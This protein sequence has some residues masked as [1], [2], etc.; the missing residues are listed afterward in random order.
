M[1][2]GWAFN[3]FQSLTELEEEQDR[4]KCNRQHIRDGLGQIYAEGGILYEAG[5]D[6]DQGDEQN[7]FAY[8]RHNH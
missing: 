7:E 3:G 8:H 5:H 4:G 1:M 6:I 2:I